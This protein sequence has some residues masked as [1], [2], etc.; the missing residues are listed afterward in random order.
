[1]SF[2][3]LQLCL[4]QRRPTR[5]TPMHRLPP[6]KDIPLLVHLSKHAN[7]RRLVLRQQGQVRI[8]KVTDDTVPLKTLRL[9]L[10]RLLRKFRRT[11]PQG[12]GG[13]RLTF[14]RLHCL[15]HLEL[16]GQSVTVPSGNVMDLLP[17]QH[18]MPVDEILQQFV[19]GV[20]DVQVSIGVGRTIMQDELF[21]V[22]RGGIGGEF[23]VEVGGLPVFLE[24]GLAFD[25]VG[26]LGEVGFGEEDGGGVDVFGSLFSGCPSS[27][28]AASFFACFAFLLLLLFLLLCV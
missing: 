9:L 24:F 27:S 19:E 28:A 14:L 23:G 26:A 10:H 6:P 25:G 17:A 22:V 8:I 5:R 16:D 7:L 21:S 2:R 20:S 4:R 1:M 15:Q 12:N 3:I 11:F 18:L 13:Q